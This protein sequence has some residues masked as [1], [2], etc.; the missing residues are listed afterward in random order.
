MA[1]F[2]KV[3]IELDRATLGYS[4]IN[5]ALAL[6][7]MSIASF[8]IY[9]YTD[10][11]KFSTEVVTVILLL[12]RFFDGAVDPFIGYY[13]D[14]RSPK[15]G[16]YKGY[17][18]YWAIPS[19]VLFVVLFLPPP[20]SGQL[21]ALWC[22]FIYIV[23][24]FCFSMM[25]VANLPLLAVICGAEK[26]KLLNTLKI[27]SS[28]AAAMIS[29]YLTF[30][31][32]NLLGR[33]SEKMGFFL[34][35]L[36]FAVIVLITSM[37]GAKNVTEKYLTSENTLSF[38]ETMYAIFKNK[39][40]MFLYCMLIFEQMS[41][42][43]KLQSTVY[44]FKYY[45]GRM[46]VLPV[47]FLVGVLSSFL[48]QPIIYWTSK[49]FRLSCLMVGGY[50]C[51]A[52]SMLIIWFSGRNLIP[53]FAGNLLYGMASAFPSNLVF[54]YASEL[55]DK[56]SE[57]ERGS[58]GGVVNSLLHVSSKIGYAL[59][60]SSVAFI[61]YLTS[62]VPDVEQ[63]PTSIMGIRIGSV[64]LTHVILLLSGLFAY[65]SFRSAPQKEA[66]PNETSSKLP[67]V[68]TD[69]AKVYGSDRSYIKPN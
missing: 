47:F 65:L 53:I 18:Y 27:A 43:V 34:T 5:F 54:V 32:V 25:E 31:L 64:A 57:D 15:A 8:L 6:V 39:Q 50:L 36:I 37:L 17:I 46:D 7:Y 42:S 13:M 20:V 10:I 61:L 67:R 24:S 49:R 45:I 4:S 51:A 55:S 66:A 12:A 58:F 40:L 35:T 41:A 2:E 19:S 21:T 63:S 60:G 22:F 59:A 23:W 44:Y 26:R 38:K 69:E 68:S 11:L 30:K 48:A 29:A 9:Y 3:R 33:G 14:S 1:Y 56:L 62:Y 52:F 28:I 16:K